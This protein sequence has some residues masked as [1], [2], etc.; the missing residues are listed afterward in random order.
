M[1]HSSQIKYPIVLSGKHPL[2]ALLASSPHISLLHAWPQLLLAT[3]RQKL[4]ILGGRNLVNPALYLSHSA[5]VSQICNQ[6]QDSDIIVTV[7]DYNLPELTWSFDEDIS[8]LLPINASSE[9]EIALVESMVAS[10]LHQI[11]SLHNSNGRILDLAFVNEPN[12]IEFLEPPTSLLRID[13]HHKPFVLRISVNDNNRNTDVPNHDDGFDFRHCNFADLNNAIL[14]I[15]WTDSFNG[16]NTDETVCVFYDKLYGI[17]NEYVPRRRKSISF[18]HPWWT[19]ELQQLR[20]A[21]RKARKRFFRTR[22]ADNWNS[23]RS[24]ES[25]YTERQ[26]AVFRDYVARLEE[27]AKHNPSSFWSFIRNRRPSNAIPTDLTLKNRSSDTPENSANLFADYFKGVHCSSSPN[28]APE[29]LGNILAFDLNLPPLVVSQNDVLAILKKLDISKGPGR[30]RLSPMFIIEC[31]VS[32]QAPLAVIFN[33]SLHEGSF[34]ELWK[35]AAITPI[36]KSGDKHEVENYRADIDKLQLWCSENGMALNISKCKAISFSRRNTRIESG[37]TIGSTQLESVDLIRDF[38][39]R[40]NEHISM[41]TAKAFAAL[42]FI[43][44]YTKDFTDIY[45]LK[46]LYCSTVR[47][48]L[49]YAIRPPSASLE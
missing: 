7:G 29:S 23:L 34:P 18:K 44:R 46:A 8:T 17:L 24:I 25:S 21:L 47:S 2:S 35:T 1:P 49:E 37:Y 36:F 13:N 33:K 22:S 20:N 14:S 16:K 6:A 5:T 4:W 45:A 26:E 19:S 11:N 31:A 10:G 42:G 9:Q 39:F 48:I 28:F 12:I 30:D 15:D 40:F 38:K 41:T 32:L 43:R 3:L 27:T